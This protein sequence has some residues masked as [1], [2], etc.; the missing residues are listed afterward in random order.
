MGEK[1]KMMLYSPQSEA[2]VNAMER[3]GVCF[4]KREYVVK[5]YE[6]SAPI[7]VAAYNAFV[8]EAQK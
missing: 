3:D 1:N 2:V 4:S 7:F 5:K 6:E 8:M